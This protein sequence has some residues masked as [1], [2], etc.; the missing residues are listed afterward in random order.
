MDKVDKH[1]DMIEKK[2][3]NKDDI[4]VEELEKLTSENKHLF[5]TI[6]LS[7]SEE[8]MLLFSGLKEVSSTIGIILKEMADMQ[9]KK[10][11]L[12]ELLKKED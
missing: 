10:A 6:S 7:A 4:S 3:V 8:S 2:L 11:K 1:I 5:D 12:L 9:D